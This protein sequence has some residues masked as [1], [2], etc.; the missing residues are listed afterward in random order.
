MGYI[1]YNPNPQNKRV[2]DCVVRAISAALDILKD[3]GTVEMFEEGYQDNPDEEYSFASG[4]NRRGGSRR[5]GYYNSYNDGSYRN[6][7]S[8]RSYTGR[9][10]SGYSREDAREH[11]I[12]KLEHLM[13]EATDDQDRMAIQKLVEQMENN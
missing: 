3:V 11:M 9:G 13:N 1:H 7:G 12:Q 2:G 4:Y 5:G 8:Y 6:G 10:R